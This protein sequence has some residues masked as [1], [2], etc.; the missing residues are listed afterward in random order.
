[1]VHMIK[2]KLKRVVMPMWQGAVG[3]A[4]GRPCGATGGGWAGPG[5]GPGGRGGRPPTRGG[6]GHPPDQAAGVSPGIVDGGPVPMHV[7]HARAGWT[8]SCHVP[9]HVGGLGVSDRVTE[10]MS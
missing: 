9:G 3:G 5:G 7:T 10:C 6:D 2:I 4:G 1:M 8:M